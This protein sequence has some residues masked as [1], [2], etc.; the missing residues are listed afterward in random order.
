MMPGHTGN[1]KMEK[2][3]HQ[4]KLTT[5]CQFSTTI[6]IKLWLI[7]KKAPTPWK[8]TNSWI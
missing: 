5:E 1:P 7:H 8:S 2:N 3:T 6:T 4:K